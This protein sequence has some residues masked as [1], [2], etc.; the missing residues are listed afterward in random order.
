MGYVLKRNDHSVASIKNINLTELIF[1]RYYVFSMILN[2]LSCNSKQ[3]G[4]VSL[5][6]IAV[7]LQ[8]WSDAVWKRSSDSVS[9]RIAILLYQHNVVGVEPRIIRTA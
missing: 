1:I 5:L 9:A 3:L 7:L 4:I 8:Y 2:P 6:R